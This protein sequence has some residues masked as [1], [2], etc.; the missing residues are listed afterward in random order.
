MIVTIIFFPSSH[1]ALLSGSMP[2]L[3]SLASVLGSGALAGARSTASSGSSTS[4]TPSIAGNLL[5]SG[6]PVSTWSGVSSPPVSH[7]HS[8]LSFPLCVGISYPGE[9]CDPNP[10]GAVCGD[11]GLAGGQCGNIPAN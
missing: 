5:F 1:P 2:S 11:K 10:V 8:G 7:P 3:E 9:T 6:A 4:V